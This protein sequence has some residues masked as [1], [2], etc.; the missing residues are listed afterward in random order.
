[1]KTL[2]SELFY[3]TS[4]FILD[5]HRH[6][7]DDVTKA[8][9]RATWRQT[10]LNSAARS[11]RRGLRVEA[12]RATEQGPGRLP[13]ARSHALAQDC[14][15]TAS[16]WGGCDETDLDLTLHRAPSRGRSAF[17]AVGGRYFPHSFWYSTHSTLREQTPLGSYQWV[18]FPGMPSLPRDD[19]SLF[20][21]IR[22]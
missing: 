8:G 15:E 21:Q 7:P 3:R 4:I 2:Q 19:P 16:L 17:L 11:V 14:R 12:R 1:M 13:T 20:F 10:W 6:V 18:S 22:L 5:E 9:K